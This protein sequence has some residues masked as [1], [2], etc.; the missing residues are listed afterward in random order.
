MVRGDECPRPPSPTDLPWLRDR[1][2]LF[3]RHGSHAY[4]T[5]TPTSDIDAKGVAVPPGSWLHGFRREFEQHEA[6]APVDL[7]IYGIRKFFRL[8]SDSNPNI[9]EVLWVDSEDLVEVKPAGERLLAARR[10]F[11]SKRARHTFSGYALSQLKRIRTHR[12][13][14]LHPPQEPPTRA[15]FGLPETMSL[16]RAQYGA[17][18]ARIRKQLAAWDVDWSGV[19]AG[20]R[21]ELR[22]QLSR[23]L[24]EVDAASDTQW[25][26]AARHVGYD[27][28]F[29]DLIQR[30]KAWRNA[31]R[32]WKQYQGWMKHRNPARAELERNHGYDTKHAM[33]LV[34]LMRMCHE[35]LRTGVV[36]VR[37]DDA[38]ELLAIRRGAW[39]YDELI[40]W[41]E[42]QEEAIERVAR[43]SDAVPERPDMDALDALCCEIVESMLETERE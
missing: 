30:E 10:A 2:I 7:V 13:W 27:E 32:E 29:I 8:A 18:E 41:A 28:N 17:A 40:G 43:E 15:E 12:R 20:V 11:L 34:R 36:R 39:D 31:R 21:D 25:Q 22:A 35:I 6:D 26:A 42:E 33:H 9:I 24:A 4:G 37:R 16:T 23:T 1:T 19:D 5:A 38:D 14:L 3:V